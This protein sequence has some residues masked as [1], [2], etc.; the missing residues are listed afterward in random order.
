MGTLGVLLLAKR[1]GILSSIKP[2]I[3]LL[4]DAGLWLG[5][6]LIKMVLNEAGEL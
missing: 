3:N 4:Q 6:D 1:R 2:A 5:D